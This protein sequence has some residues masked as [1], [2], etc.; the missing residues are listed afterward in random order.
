MIKGSA[1]LFSLLHSFGECGHDLVNGA[2]PVPLPSFSE[3]A[4]AEG[5]LP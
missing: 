1:I 5:R 3:G 4:H 2:Q